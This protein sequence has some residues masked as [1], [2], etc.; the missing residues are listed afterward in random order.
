MTVLFLTVFIDLIGF[1]IVLPLLPFF[2]SHFGASGLMVTGLSS[3]FSFMQFL[4]APFWGKL[5]DRWGRRPVLLC[6]LAGSTL[7]YLALGFCT[8][9][10]QIFATRVLAG[11][12]GANISVANAYIADITSPENRSRGMGLIGAAF[13]LGFVLG[14]GIGASIAYFAENPTR[15]EQVYHAI[16]WVAGAICGINFLIACFTLVESYPPEKRLHGSTLMKLAWFSW[17]KG[18]SNRIIGFLIVLYFVLGF[19]FS[20]FENLFA[21]LIRG[22][23]GY[24][25]KEG[26]YFFLFL[27]LVVALVQG[28]LI[29]QLVKLFGERRLILFAG[30]LFAASMILIPWCRHLRHLLMV[31]TGLGIGQG[32]NR[33]TI[34][35]LISQQVRPE[36]QGEVMGLAQSAGSLAR[37]L[38]PLVGGLL[39]DHAGV[40][41]P[42]V[43]AGL[44]MMVTLGIGS[45][46]LLES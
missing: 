37:I 41:T 26:N 12:F 15:P 43:T 4:S 35:G 39:F 45:K 19:G 3:V 46:C 9:F 42:F 36:E 7:S 33:S 44:L 25:I 28:G 11:F 27:G 38:G 1:G 34:M 16:G 23:F 31:L 20:N 22:K 17:G 13:G 8:S 21:L 6:S 5:S 29:G 40:A 18:F 24:D 2:A 14:P 32:L 10:G 30:V